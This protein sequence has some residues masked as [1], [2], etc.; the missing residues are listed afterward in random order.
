MGLFSKLK[1]AFF[2]EEYVEVDEPAVKKKDKADEPVARKVE[3]DESKKEDIDIISERDLIEDENEKPFP[4][5]FDDEDFKA[6]EDVDFDKTGYDL[7]KFE[8]QS[9]HNNGSSKY[10]TYRHDYQEEIKQQ[11]K[12][13]KPSPNISPVY[14]IIEDKDAKNE[15]IIVKKEV[16]ITI[17]SNKLNIDTIRE[18]AYGDLTGELDIN[19]LKKA[20]LEKE[21]IVYDMN[22]TGEQPIVDQVTIGD[23]SEY[24]EDLG[25]QYN[26]DYKDRSHEEATGRI[27]SKDDLAAEEDPAYEIYEDKEELVKEDIEEKTPEQDEV[28]EEES[29]KA[30]SSEKNETEEESIE[31]NL[32][33]LIDS[34]YEEKE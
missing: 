16:R 3:A 23:A 28:K 13:F 18:K 20:N 4:M 1:E 12:L 17:P 5:I 24:F 33:D 7:P 22:N 19:K 34:M 11:K 15:E 26:V 27:L 14:G 29:I 8:S 9:Y 32:F 25:L 2:E 31:D 10:E 21:T 6:E 30:E